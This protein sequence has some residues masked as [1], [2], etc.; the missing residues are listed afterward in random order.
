MRIYIKEIIG[1]PNRNSIDWDKPLK[2]VFRFNPQ[3]KNRIKF[4]GGNVVRMFLYT[5][6]LRQKKIVGIGNEFSELNDCKYFHSETEKNMNAIY[7]NT[8]S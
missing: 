4:K 5:N 6:L 8:N 7:R 1:K 2:I 3:N